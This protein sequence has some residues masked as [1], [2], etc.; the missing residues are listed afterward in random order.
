MD[1]RSPQSAFYTRIS[2]KTPE[3]RKAMLRQQLAAKVQW[4]AREEEVAEWLKEKFGIE[5]EEAEALMAEAL[6]TRRNSARERALF[7][8]M[9]SV[10][11]LTFVVLFVVRF[12]WGYDLGGQFAVKTEF[13]TPVAVAAA[14]FSIT[15]LVKG[16]RE[17]CGKGKE[18]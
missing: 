3:E 18:K 16:V 14:W 11:G 15:A 13:L 9:L 12:M 6:R 4:G 1:L 8:I 5:G 2:M 17:W 7:K 10:I